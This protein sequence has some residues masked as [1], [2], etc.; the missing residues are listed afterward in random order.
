MAYNQNISYS[1]IKI[2]NQI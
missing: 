2:P 1:S